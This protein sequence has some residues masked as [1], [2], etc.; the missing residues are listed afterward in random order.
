LGHSC[1]NLLGN[2]D[3]VR[4][5]RQAE[6]GGREHRVDNLAHTLAGAALA[7]AGLKKK[8]GLG[9]ATL[10]IA[11]NLPDV[12]VIALFFNENLAFRRGIT[13]G[14]VGLLIL[15]PI[16]ALLMVQFDRWQTR[17]GKRPEGRHHVHFGWLVALA[18]IGAIS[19][20]ALDWLNVYGVRLLAP[21]S[22]RWFYGDTLFIIDVWL[23]TMLTFGVVLSQRRARRG[24]A[25]SQR[26]ALISIAAVSTY[27]VAMFALTIETEA[28]VEEQMNARGFQVEA[29]AAGPPPINP[30]VREFFFKGR[31]SAAGEG[32]VGGGEADLFTPNLIERWVKPYPDNLERLNVAEAAERSK[33]LGDFMFWA[34]FPYAKLDGDTLVVTDAR[35]AGAPNDGVFTVRVPAV[36]DAGSEAQPDR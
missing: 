29:V 21:F 32:H 5:A 35:Y 30:F 17:R 10:M 19:H 25:N 15:P 16:L 14:P 1:G 26:P 18:Y 2:A 31:W 6:P 28:R 9:L 36:P 4:L 33:P 20:P 11:A 8:T 34:R 13:H 24:A 23:W 22:D 27:I 7:E 12:D 3:R